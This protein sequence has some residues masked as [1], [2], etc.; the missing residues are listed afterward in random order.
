MPIEIQI[1][2]A[3]F[4]PD[5][6]RGEPR[7]VGLVVR[8]AA[9]EVLT[10]FLLEGDQTQAVPKYLDLREYG[11]TVS[12]WKETIEKYGVK[13]L[14]WVGKRKKLSQ[15]YYLEFMGGEMV[16]DF[17]FEKLFKELVL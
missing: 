14:Q 9:D 11:M 12:G 1:Y 3:K 2:L 8:T 13:A 17:D 6:R 4:L 7:N 10:K 5:P 16:Q 15:R